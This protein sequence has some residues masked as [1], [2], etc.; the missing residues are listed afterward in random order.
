MLTLIEL[1]VI[2]WLLIDNRHKDKDHE[3]AKLYKDAYDEAKRIIRSSEDI[4]NPASEIVLA[5]PEKKSKNCNNFKTLTTPNLAIKLGLKTNELMEKLVS[6]GYLEIS[7]NNKYVTEKGKEVGGEQC[8]I[9]SS[10]YPQWPPDFNPVAIKKLKTN[11]LA[12]KY[13]QPSTKI[14]EQLEQSGYIEYRDK[15]PCLTAKWQLA[16]GEKSDSSFLWSEDIIFNIEKIHSVELA[17]K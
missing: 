6:L 7:G 13:R 10:F 9:N 4:N 8:E 11:D 1:W 16:G 3:E 5:K 14:L 17:K 15:K 12:K 2:V